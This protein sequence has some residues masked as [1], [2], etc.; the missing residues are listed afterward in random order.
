MNLDQ[1]PQLSPHDYAFARQMAAQWL[2]DK[3][4]IRASG[5]L[6]L[7]SA[8][9][10]VQWLNGSLNVEAARATYHKYVHGQGGLVQEVPHETIQENQ[11]NRT[12]S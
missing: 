8:F 12:S 10:V 3:L 1:Y 4:P 6:R 9:T 2:D 11:T 7:Y 5:G